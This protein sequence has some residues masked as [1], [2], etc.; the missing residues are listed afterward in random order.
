MEVIGIGGG[1]GVGK[2][3]VCDVLVS[4]HPRD[5]EV[6]HLD[7]Y[8]LEPGPGLPKVDSMTNWEHPDIV[9]WD[10]LRQTI[11]T[12]QSAQDVEIDV[13]ARRINPDSTTRTSSIRVIRPR[14]VLLVEG[15]LALYAGI[16]DVYDR[17]FYL[18]LDVETRAQRRRHARGG[19]D[20]LSGDDR[21]VDMVLRPMHSTYI[22]PTKVNADLIIDVG[23]RTANEIASLIVRH[24]RDTL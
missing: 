16:A 11:R 18:D 24:I 17:A 23:T 20:T 7:D 22:E 5:F 8:Q 19:K 6:I 13:R 12:L 9:R 15:H 14:P 3:T 2:S 10:S 1:S 4:N 21:Y